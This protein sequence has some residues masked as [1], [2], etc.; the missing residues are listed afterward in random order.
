M[1]LSDFENL[2]LDALIKGDPEE[3]LIREQ[4]KTATVRS[5]DYSG[6]G[7]FTEIEVAAHAPRLAK[8]NRYI[9]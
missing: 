2:V 6:V 8:S 3:A 9:E 4:L 1:V 7:L 5:R